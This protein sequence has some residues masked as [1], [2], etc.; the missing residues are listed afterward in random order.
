MQDVAQSCSEKA[1]EEEGK[2]TVHKKLFALFVSCIFFRFAAIQLERNHD[3]LMQKR[4]IKR[5]ENLAVVHQWR[6]LSRVFACIEPRN[7]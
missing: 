1:R 6:R 2:K 4:G 5:F 7:T 3:K